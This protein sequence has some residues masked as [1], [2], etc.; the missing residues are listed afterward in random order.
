MPDLYYLLR[1]PY[2]FLILGVISFSAAVVWTYTGKAWVRF[3]GWVYR[4]KE[5]KWFWW[6]VA[7]YYL[8]GV[9]FIGISLY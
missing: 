9:L 7:L 8:V 6:E 2:I 4:A 5:P 3:D 1:P